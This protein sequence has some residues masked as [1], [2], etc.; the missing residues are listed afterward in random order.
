MRASLVFSL[1]IIDENVYRITISIVLA[2]DCLAFG[3]DML[4]FF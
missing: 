4:V 1:K 2:L 3:T